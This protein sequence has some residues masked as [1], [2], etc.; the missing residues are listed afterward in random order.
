ME[1][2]REERSGGRYEAQQITARRTDKFFDRI[3]VN[4]LRHEGTTYD[5]ELEEYFNKTGVGQ[6]VDMVRERVYELIATS[7]PHLRE[8]CGR[9]LE[10]RRNQ[11]AF[12]YGIDIT[13]R[14]CS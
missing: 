3:E 12:R 1:Q 9:Q 5:D 13:S 14:S 11:A 8:E 6:A 4:F 7:Y 2:L 10:Q